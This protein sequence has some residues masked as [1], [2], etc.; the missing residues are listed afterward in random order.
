M[1][2]IFVSLN[3]QE[4]L[5]GRSLAYGRIFQAGK[6]KNEVPGKEENSGLPGTPLVLSRFGPPGRVSA[7]GGHPK[8]R[9]KQFC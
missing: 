7:F 8:T 6:V 1:A 4:S 5:A 9:K 2:L 3:E